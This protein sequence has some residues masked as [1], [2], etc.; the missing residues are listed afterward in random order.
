LNYSV[1]RRTKEIGIRSALGAQR[2]DLIYLVTR[3]L[4]ALVGGGLLAGLLAMVALMSLL[5]SL[6]FGIRAADPLLIAT[7]ISAFVLSSVA[8]AAL[9]AGRALAIDPAVA[10]RDD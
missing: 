8:A 5:S 3:D 9:P 4:I 10:L 6:L 2:Q 1:A 7:A